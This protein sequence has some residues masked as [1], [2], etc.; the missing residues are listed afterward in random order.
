MVIGACSDPPFICLK[1]KRENVLPL[2]TFVK[3]DIIGWYRV[4]LLIGINFPTHEDV[5]RDLFAA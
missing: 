5:L 1:T 2:P 3:T 4:G